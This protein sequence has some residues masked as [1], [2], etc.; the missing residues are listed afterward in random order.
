M[1]IWGLF[2][3]LAVLVTGCGPSEP[4]AN[5]PVESQVRL[6]NRKDTLTVSD[7]HVHLFKQM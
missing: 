3:A 2:A 7:Q 6:K 5:A 1:R 4:G